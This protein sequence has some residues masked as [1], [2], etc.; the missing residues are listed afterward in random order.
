[1]ALRGYTLLPPW[2]LACNPL[3]TLE[4]LN[5]KSCKKTARL[6]YSS[7]VRAGTLLRFNCNVTRPE[8]VRS[9][10]NS[11]DFHKKASSEAVRLVGFHPQAC[12]KY[13][14]VIFTW[15]F[16]GVLAFAS[17]IIV[18]IFLLVEQESAQSAEKICCFHI[19]TSFE[20]AVFEAGGGD[21]SPIPPGS[22][23]ANG[24]I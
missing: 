20:A 10:L 19:K 8:L 15:L 11:L 7:G 2:E 21:V 9:N 13:D 5:I 1:L 18:F 17:Y 22:A 14:D 24:H 4:N 23:T 3:K 16:P 6:Q 12:K